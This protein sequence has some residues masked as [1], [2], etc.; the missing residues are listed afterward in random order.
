MYLR[1]AFWHNPLLHR[2]ENWSSESGHERSKVT[3]PLTGA[4]LSLETL[5]FGKS[6]TALSPL[7][8]KAWKWQGNPN[9][10]SQEVSYQKGLNNTTQYN[11]VAKSLSLSENLPRKHSAALLYS[12][13]GILLVRLLNCWAR[14]SKSIFSSYS[15]S[16]GIEM[17]RNQ[18]KAH[19]YFFFTIAEEE[20]ALNKDREIISFTHDLRK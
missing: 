4:D 14:R 11:L 8:S 10:V 2:E 15:N 5:A 20:V 13:D 9:P 7:Y 17:E 3:E 6:P 1:E 12:W 18:K 19:S 16:F